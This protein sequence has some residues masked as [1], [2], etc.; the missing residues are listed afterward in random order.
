MYIYICVAMYDI[1]ICYTIHYMLYYVHYH[2]CEVLQRRY[3]RNKQ[4][5][6]MLMLCY[7]YC[8]YSSIISLYVCVCIYIYI[9]IY[10]I[11]T[12]IYIY[13]YIMYSGRERERERAER[14][15]VW[16]CRA[17]TGRA[18]PGRHRLNGYLA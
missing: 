9:Y 2:P 7:L 5:K 15:F 11:Y 1:L 12:H 10:I 16:S 13:I 18:L 17:E 6:H 14:L 4:H 8:S 3:L